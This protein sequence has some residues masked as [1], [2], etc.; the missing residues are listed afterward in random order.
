M[1][2]LLRSM[3]SICLLIAI[4]VSHVQ[5]A[6]PVQK[7]LTML[8]AE[9]LF[10]DKEFD[11]ADVDTLVWSKLSPSYF[12]TVLADG[13]GKDEPNKKYD[14]VRVDVRLNNLRLRDRRRGRV[15]A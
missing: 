10:L 12:T 1:R 4:G 9:R 13:S 3:A 8:N 2:Y 7:D 11:I 14:V 5:S 15:S 6:D